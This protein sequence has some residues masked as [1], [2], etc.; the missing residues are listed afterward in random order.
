[1]AVKYSGK[2]TVVNSQ[3][4]EV[5]FP[6]GKIPKMGAVIDIKTYYKTNEKFETA[7]IVSSTTV[8]A[9][10]LTKMDG[11]G[12]GSPATT[13]NIGIEIPVGDEVLG[14][15]IS[16]LGD[17]Y[18]VNEPGDWAKKVEIMDVNTDD[19]IKYEI[20]PST[21]VLETGVKV[22]DFLLP[23]PRGGKVGLLGGAG[24]G[25]TV[26]VQELIN[27]F[28]KNHDG[29]SVFTGIGERTRE[30]HELLNEAKELGFL[31]KTALVFAQMNE[32][33]GAR[34][35][36]A[37]SGI[38][39][40]EYFRDEYKKDVLLFVDNIFRLVQAGSEISSLLGRLPSAVGY[41]PTLS[42]EMGAFQ[43]RI[44]TT[45]NG[46]ITS[47]QAVYIPADD[48]TDPS[49]VAS[50]AHFDSTIIL[51]RD[52]AAAGIYPAV[53]PLQ[54]NSAL[55]NRGYISDAHYEAATEALKI[56]EAYNQ[57]QDI[58]MILGLDGLTDEDKQIVEKSRRIS[59][60]LSQPFFV[61]EKFSGSAGKTVPL[62]D[63]IRSFQ[64][65]INGEVNHIPEKFFLYKG[66]IDEV[67]EAYNETLE[68][69][70]VK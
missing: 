41:Q 63:T 67:I 59:K 16:L 45:K 30:G 49:A 26:V 65:I 43:E 62:A 69:E 61:A 66:S 58:I 70:E 11:V 17:P 4:I 39:I 68:S 51:D 3:V 18:D 54:S 21:V 19:R 48:L 9:Y 1:M 31:N 15:V 38:R 46:A 22:I 42:S 34:F 6:A 13:E 2:V 27:T 33:P 23:I 57:L 8:K 44:G 20:D 47:I 53:S 60:F 50:F 64:M 14:R 28:I 37:Y 35:R 10:C 24:V 52:I 5:Q 36:A 56:L 12:I 40:A 29:L 7:A 55:L 32:V 25:K